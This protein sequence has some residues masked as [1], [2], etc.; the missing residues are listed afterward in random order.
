MANSMATS[1]GIKRVEK[2]HSPKNNLIGIIVTRPKGQSQTFLQK[3]QNSGFT[4]FDLPGITIADPQDLQAA[5]ADLA[6]VSTYD[7]LLFTSPNSV[8]FAKK[9]GLQFDKIKG[10]ISIGSGTERALQPYIEGKESITAPKPYTSEALVQT[11]KEHNIA[12]KRILIISGEGGRRL[13]DKAINDLQGFG[14]YCDVYRREA[15]R[16]EMLDLKPILE[17]KTQSPSTDSPKR[18]YLVISSQEAFNNLLP[19]LDR[20]QLRAQIDGVFVGSERLENI[21]K[22]EGFERVIVARSA[23][24]KDLWQAIEEK[25][26]NFNSLNNSYNHPLNTPSISPDND[27]E[28]SMTQELNNQ[29]SKKT[30]QSISPKTSTNEATTVDKE[31]DAASVESTQKPDNDPPANGKRANQK[32]NKKRG[33]ARKEN[34]ASEKVATE[35]ESVEKEDLPVTET[36][37]DT[38]KAD[39]TEEKNEQK[40]ESVKD[41]TE[42]STLKESSMVEENITT[43]P[44]L[45]APQV[46]ESPT[47]ATA[48]SPRPRQGLTYLALILA[49]GGLGLGG[50]SFYKGSLEKDDKIA[51]LE[52]A[53][54]SDT[55]TINSLKGEIDTLNQSLSTLK[56]TTDK[57]AASD[58]QSLS[59]QV[60]TVAQKHEQLN[61]S[62]AESAKGLQAQIDKLAA[63]QKEL[64]TQSDQINN[65]AK[66]SNQAITIANDFDK[67]LAA[68]ELQQNVVL[69]EAKELISTIK[70]I[71]DLEMLRTTE[72]DYLLKVAIQKVQYDKDYKTAGQILNSALDKLSQIN[73]INFNETKQLLQ[74]NIETLKTLTPLDLVDITNRLEKVT[75]LL[76]KAPLKSDS[77][78]VNLK[79]EIFN[80][81]A[82]E[83]ESWTDKLTSS[84]K[85]LVVI[86]DK[87][88][89]VPEL[90]AKEDRFFLLQNT[91]LELTAAKIAL[92]QDQVTLFKHSVETVQSWVKTYFDED[93]ADVR[94]AIQQLQWLLDAKLEVTP[95]NIE[96][97]LTDFE[98]TL[99]AYKGAQ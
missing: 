20:H 99:R 45:E 89:E 66:V 85:H 79:N 32:G 87:R 63:T 75:V 30:E 25:F 3:L 31:L 92:L 49:L 90:M 15:P 5:L 53:L 26:N 18:L 83:G 17:F 61:Q 77:A 88:A 73:S 12:G 56:V 55:A 96:R 52:S 68:Q 62:L 21:V 98:A 7:Y 29:D 51:Q 67:K 93:N 82:P 27:K 50:F 94:E 81:G 38:P 41:S 74:A 42:T 23:L 46:E 69:N 34:Q 64:L 54:A 8:R 72:V 1:M 57:I 33:N 78:L 36:S 84:L 80:Q 48:E 97:T 58:A 2:N 43:T 70:N 4:A 28:R 22:S 19:I 95:P 39:S 24:E 60:A 10:F 47:H 59:G 6:Q 9:L 37:Q 44:Q 65:I 11:L 40:N 13:L 71:T 16:E 35:T 14:K 76:Q 91:Q 86:E